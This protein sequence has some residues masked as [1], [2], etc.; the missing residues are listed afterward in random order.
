MFVPLWRDSG[1]FVP[2]W[3]GRGGGH[4]S[5]KRA[6]RSLSPSGGIRGRCGKNWHDSFQNRPDP[7]FRLRG[8]GD[9]SLVC[10]NTARHCCARRCRSCS[11]DLQVRLSAGPKP[12]PAIRFPTKCLSPSGGGSGEVGTNWHDSFQNR[13][14]PKFRLRGCGDDS[15]VCSNTA[16]TLLFPTLLCRTL[17]FL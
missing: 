11:L 3:R 1:Q 15:L 7:K 9:D 2:L 13:P 4:P 8:C 17:L 16:K 5:A 12:R 10:S 6:R 14:D